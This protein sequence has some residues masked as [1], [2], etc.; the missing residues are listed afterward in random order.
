ME[1]KKLVLKNFRSH[2]AL[3][4]D[5]S[6]GA[7]AIIGTNGTG[8]SSVVEAILFLLTGDGYGKLKQEMITVGQTSGYVVGHFIINDKPAILERHTDTSKVVFN[9]DGRVYKKSSEV[10]AIWDSLFQIDKHI[11]KNVVIANQ[12]EIALLFNGSPADKEK[13]F[14]KI[15]LVPN[16]TRFRDVI[17]QK[18]IKNAPPKYVV[19]DLVELKSS[20]QV[21]E[22]IVRLAEVEKSALFLDEAEY[23][24]LVERKSFLAKVEISRADVNRLLSIIPGIEAELEKYRVEKTG[25]E[26]KVASIQIDVI[27]EELRKLDLAK[28]VDAMRAELLAKKGALVEPELRFDEDK[29]RELADLESKLQECRDRRNMR[30]KIAEELRDKLK[31]YEKSGV[32]VG[33]CPTCGTE[34][35]DIVNVIAHSKTE[36][37]KL[38]NEL[39]QISAEVSPI[40]YEIRLLKSAKFAWENYT[41]QRDDLDQRLLEYGESTFS[42]EDYDLFQGV[43]SKHKEY[44]DSIKSLDVSIG[45]CT[46]NLNSAR[47]KL[48]GVTQYDRDLSEFD[49]EVIFVTDA[50]KHASETR[51]KIRKAEVDLATAKEGLKR[52]KIEYDENVVMEESNKRREKYLN[53][54]ESLYDLFHTTKFPR[55]LIHTYAEAVSSHMAD[56]LE[57]FNFP[58]KALVNESFDVE[59]R[60]PDGHPLPSVSG[61]QQ[62]MIGFSLRLALHNMF[63]SAFP[64]MIIDEGSYG[65]A[66]EAAKNYFQIIK[67]LNKSN[68]FKQ[69][70]VIDHNPDLIDYVDHAITL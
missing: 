59:I 12:G 26:R 33:V 47:I 17:W 36:L 60:T 55:A 65:L 63:S 20:I 70:I 51:E 57:A 42:Q 6:S 29:E 43:V 48:A 18:Y 10:N 15:F 44:T 69:V 67:G 22:E 68:K 56:V 9:Y 14:Q 64:L 21:E 1:L 53:I 8:K 19:K 23:E 5:F 61:G 25:L 52:L 45:T 30:V 40:E 39:I 3:T 50:L 27:R 7:T 34:L 49:A 58:Y 28:A 16:T 24:K 31:D 62:V 66:T 32:A 11:V 37:A 2:K 46:A 13:L 41:K 4:L 38:D 35:T 54:L